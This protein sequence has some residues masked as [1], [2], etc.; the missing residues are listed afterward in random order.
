MEIDDVHCASSRYRNFIIE[1]K[2]VE[3][4]IESSLVFLIRDPKK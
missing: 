1:S 3:S 4:T 2:K